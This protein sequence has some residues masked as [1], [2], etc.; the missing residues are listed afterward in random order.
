MSRVVREHE[1]GGA[2]E[3][4]RT[5][6]KSF[7]A[8]EKGLKKKVEESSLIRLHHR[9]LG[10]DKKAIL[11]LSAFGKPMRRR[12]KRGEEP[13]KL[14]GILRSKRLSEEKGPKSLRDKEVATDATE[15]VLKSGGWYASRRA[16]VKILKGTGVREVEGRQERTKPWDKVNERREGQMSSRGKNSPEL[17]EGGKNFVDHTFVLALPGKNE[18]SNSGS[19]RESGREGSWGFRRADITD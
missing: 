6:P 11:N 17:I 2:I 19:G 5:T 4:N 10:G 7:A 14:E 16:L 18:K 3:K 9:S 1:H 15:T 8:R 12:K 13:S